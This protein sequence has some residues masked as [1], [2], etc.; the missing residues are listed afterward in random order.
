[1]EKTSLFA[2][3]LIFF[4]P[5]F[6]SFDFFFFAKNEKQKGRRG[7]GEEIVLFLVRGFFLR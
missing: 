2:K 5:V 3:F 4:S 1:M 6:W 7:Q